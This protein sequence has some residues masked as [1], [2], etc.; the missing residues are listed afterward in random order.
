VAELVITTALGRSRTHQLGDQPVV[1]GRD[2][3]CDIPLDDLGA[4]RRHAT[5]GPEDGGYVI[6]DLGSKNGTFVNDQPVPSARLRHG[7]AIL[8][9][10]ATVMFKDGGDDAQ[11]S[12]VVVADEKPATQPTTY[13]GPLRESEL[14]QRR[15]E[16]LYDLTDRLTRLRDRD[17]LLGDA[18]DVCFEMLRF[19]RGAIAVRQAAGNLVDWPVVRNL[20]GSEGELTVSRTILSSALT[21]GERVIVNDT[22][23]GPI[24]PTVSIVRNNIRSAMCVPLLSGDRNLGVVYGDRVSSGTTYTKEDIDFL[25]GIARLITTGL[26]NAQLL[27][28]QKLKLQ[29]ENEMGMARQIQT[30]LFPKALP[31]RSDLR[32]AALNMP[33]YHVS[34]DYYDFI[35]LSGERL[36]FVVADVTG[37]GVAASLLMANLQA[38]VRMTLPTDRPLAALMTDWNTLI[39]AN[40]DASRFITCLV[41]IVDPHA[42]MLELGVAGHHPPHIVRTHQ[43]VETLEVEPDYPFGVMDN[44]EYKTQKFPLGDAPCTLVSYTDGVIEAA[45]VGEDLY[46]TERTL[47]VLGQADTLEPQKLIDKLH[48]D[49]SHF[50]G[51][52]PQGD[53]ITITAVHLS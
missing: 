23:D 20:R 4:S 52:A 30:G 27:D 22:A 47:E 43:P 44:I 32:V 45:N 10:S 42:R 12:S 35:E 16:I 11:P 46:G 17:E 7:D 29:L 26:I 6:K 25:A 37:E 53:D 40:T 41:G 33:G 15:L 13:A 50:T 39:E 3:G 5:V 1:L 49:V 34:G 2:P 28:E 48:R 38:A 8:I 18:M 24:D 36:A 31:E 19:E 14:S 51:S 21:H 9:G